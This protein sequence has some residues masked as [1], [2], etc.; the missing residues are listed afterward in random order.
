MSIDILTPNGLNIRL[1]RRKPRSMWS[2]D[3]IFISQERIA[4]FIQG[5]FLG[6]YDF[7]LDK[8]L[9]FFI[10]GRYEFSNKGADMFIESLARL[11]HMLKSSGSDVTIVAF[12]IFPTPTNNFNIESLRGQ[13]VAKMLRDTVQNIQSDIGKRLYEICLK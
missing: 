12:M 13:S 5:H 11:N 1:Y 9:Y 3:P 2:A 7:D 4:N 6:H 10:A 8:T